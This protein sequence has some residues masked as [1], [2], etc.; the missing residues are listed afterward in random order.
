MPI[1][2]V[3]HL[4]LCRSQLATSRLPHFAQLVT[5]IIDVVQEV[6]WGLC[7]QAIIF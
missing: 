7:I 3:F 1:I 5:E 4:D 2:K 6:L